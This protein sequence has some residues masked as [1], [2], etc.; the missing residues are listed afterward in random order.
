[1]RNCLYKHEN[2]RLRFI[3]KW[4]VERDVI[5]DTVIIRDFFENFFAVLSLFYK[6]LFFLKEIFCI[7]AILNI[8]I[9]VT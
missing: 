3:N 5:L 7:Y 9:L 2:R 4:L 6:W 8:T 1:M